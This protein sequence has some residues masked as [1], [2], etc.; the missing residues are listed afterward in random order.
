L[1][2]LPGIATKQQEYRMKIVFL[3]IRADR[4][5]TM[6]VPLPLKK[7]SNGS[8]PDHCNREGVLI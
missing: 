5:D 1:D 6:H 4:P 2:F 7:I 8:A 3:F